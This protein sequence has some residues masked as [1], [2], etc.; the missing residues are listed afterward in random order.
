MQLYL[1]FGHGMMELSRELLTE[2]GGGGIILSPRDLTEDQLQRTARNARGAGAEPLLDPQCYLRDADHHRL[3]SY[4]YW[5]T[6]QSHSTVSLLSGDGCRRLLRELGELVQRLELE[7]HILPGILAQ[8][9]DSD[10]LALHEQLIEAGEQE[11]GGEPLIATVA[12][13]PDSARSE[14]QVE[15]IVERA[16]DWPVE[17]FYLVCEPPGG[18]LVEDPVWLANTLILASGL[19]LLGKEVMVGYGSHQMLALAAAKT[20]VLAAGTWMNVRT[21]DR[22]RLY[23]QPNVPKQRGI[24]FYCPQALTEYQPVF[25]DMAQ[26]RG[27]LDEM[28]P[29]SGLGS[30][31][32]D[33]LFAGPQPST[34]QWREPL[35]FRHYLTCL[36]GQCATLTASSFDQALGAQRQLLDSAES[37]HQRLA[38]A[39]VFSTGRDFGPIFNV[40]RSA[41]TD[42]EL[43]RG[44]R[45]RREW[46]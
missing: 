19:K 42:L 3:T 25:L 32:A 5:Q 13:S 39:G 41:L 16:A 36:R 14:E 33:A 2:W 20:D 44:A 31:Y 17:G 24:W 6:Y 28:R 22:D 8:A 15:A 27:L 11:L 37:L 23:N 9:V 18:Y 38:Q 45:L 12:L 43:A 1:Q 46:T 10:W 21:F 40:N 29:D 35:A 34:V 26:R 4:E 7:R 30:S